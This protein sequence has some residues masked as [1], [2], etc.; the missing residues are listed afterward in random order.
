VEV[1]EAVL[2]TVGNN[3]I[4]AVGECV[5]VGDVLGTLVGAGGR[6]DDVG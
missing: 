4:V 3:V 1:L 6:G 5:L 2:V